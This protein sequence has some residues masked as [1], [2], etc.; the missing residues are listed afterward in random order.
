LPARLT[1]RPRIL[2][3]AYRMNFNLLEIVLHLQRGERGDMPVDGAVIIAV[4]PLADLRIKLADV[5]SALVEAVLVH[6]FRLLRFKLVSLRFPP[7]A[8]F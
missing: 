5:L 1:V 3:V 7:P 2:A 8:G 4:H 6:P